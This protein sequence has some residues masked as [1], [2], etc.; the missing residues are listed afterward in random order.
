MVRNADRFTESRDPLFAGDYR[1]STLVA[2]TKAVGLSLTV[3]AAQEG[4]K[5][6]IRIRPHASE[7]KLG[8][9]GLPGCCKSELVYVSAST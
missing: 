3:E 7:S 9:A 8:L 6:A 1:L 5:P 2:V 4:L